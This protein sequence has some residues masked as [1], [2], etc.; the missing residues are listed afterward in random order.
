MRLSVVRACGLAA[1]SFA[2]LTTACADRPPP[3]WA[4]G[5]S[6]LAFANASWRNGEGTYIELRADGRVVANGGLLFVLDRAGR[7]YDSQNEP[8]AMLM[9]DGNIAGVNEQHLGRIGVTNASPPRGRVA[10][11]SVLPDGRVIHFEPDGERTTDGLWLGCNGAQ[12]RTC[13]LVTQLV[14]L[15]RV[16]A[17]ARTPVS[18]GVGVGVGI[19]P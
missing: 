6:P 11:L 19:W 15:E 17:A 2:L 5:G 18:V 14:T 7:V 4:T 9:R 16:A 12:F 3:G 1:A 8:V 10:W 13:T